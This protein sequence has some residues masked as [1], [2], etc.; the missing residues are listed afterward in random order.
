MSLLDVRCM[1]RIEPEQTTWLWRDRIPRHDAHRDNEVRAALSRFA[2][3]GTRRDVTF[4]CVMHLN[5]S[6]GL[7][8]MYRTGGSIAFPGL[9]RSSY[10]V[11]PDKED[12]ARRLFLPLKNN[13]ARACGGMAFR[14]EGVEVAGMEGTYPRI[15]WEQGEVDVDA[16]DALR[17]PE[18]PHSSALGRACA[19]L[20][21]R[22]AAG[23]VLAKTVVADAE[24]AGHAERTIDRAKKKLR[25]RSTPE[26]TGKDRQWFWELPPEDPPNNAKEGTDGGLGGDG[27]LGGLGTLEERSC[28]NGL[29]EERQGRQECQGRQH[30][31]ESQTSEVDGEEGVGR[32]G[33]QER[34]HRQGSQDSQASKPP[35]EDAEQGLSFAAQETFL[36]EDAAIQDDGSEVGS[37]G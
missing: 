8:S 1:A 33:R 32:Q 3:L 6:V 23:R 17:P 10:L 11:A 27:T 18:T 29:G 15:T 22:L 19:W 16:D 34:Q 12:P 24:E 31:Q 7:P 25:V 30:R 26:G 37:R 9:A 5:K 13:L 35:S 14:L 21:E 36:T 2:Q 4:L 28:Q 20:E